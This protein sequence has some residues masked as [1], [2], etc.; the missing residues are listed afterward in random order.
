MEL[1]AKPDA[2]EAL[3]RMEAWWLRENHDRP[4]LTVAVERPPSKLSKTYP[5]ERE[6]WLDFEFRVD[7]AIEAVETGT[8]LAETFPTFEPNLGPDIIS[9]IFGLNLEFAPDTS[10]GRPIVSSVDE[11]LEI[12][13]SFEAP[14]WKEVEK[15][16]RMGLEAG[17][18]RW[19]TLFTDLHA[20]ADIP[21]AL[22]GQEAFCMA[23]ADDLTAARR[24]VEHVTQGALEAYR[25]QVQP[26]E[27]KGLPIGTWLSAFSSKRSH[28][29]QADFSGLIGVEMFHRAVL[30]SVIEEMRQAERNIYHLDGEAA[31]KHLDILLEVKEIDA[32]QWVYGDGH[33]PAR[34]WLD[35]YRT[36]LKAG[37]GVRVEAQDADD[38][39]ELHKE[40]G[41]EGVWYGANFGPLSL[42]DADAL[43]HAISA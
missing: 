1:R 30:P 22:M 14:L 40:L 41:N 37:K 16:Q 28:V 35:V 23:L 43:L 2:A 33:G 4:I 27:R 19:I 17:D 38:I 6:R 32:I 20:N 12:E 36:I 7:Q 24:A 15:L 5:T 3:D 21:A 42:A 25:R 34:R 10:W 26:I 8:Y 9:T 29:P 11:I 13:P 31:L 39:L 18:G